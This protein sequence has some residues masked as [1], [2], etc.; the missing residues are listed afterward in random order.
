MSKISM[1][2]KVKE[3]IGFH[4][5]TDRNTAAYFNSFGIEYIPQEVWNKIKDNSI[6]HSIFRIQDKILLCGDFIVSLS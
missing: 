3:H 4:Y 2:K 1:T 5:F 6:T